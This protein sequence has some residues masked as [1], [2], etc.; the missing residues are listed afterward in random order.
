MANK[1]K[2]PEQSPVVPAEPEQP[3]QIAPAAEPNAA[4]DGNAEAPAVEPAL[5][6]V[7]PGPF[8]AV[9]H[10]WAS[11]AGNR[12]RRVVL[13]GVEPAA[14]NAKYPRLVSVTALHPFAT[15]AERDAALC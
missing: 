2:K 14:P 7:D 6:V 13:P 1:P 10:V 15:K 4:A 5:V 12:K 9:E 8:L 3:V 11:E